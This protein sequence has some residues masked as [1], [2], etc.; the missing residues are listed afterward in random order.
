MFY[1]ISDLKKI[2]YLQKYIDNRKSNLKVAMRSI[3]YTVGWYNC[4]NEFIQII[5]P[6]N[7]DSRLE[8]SP[9]LYSFYDLRHILTNVGV[10]LSLEVNKVNGKV[11][12]SIPPYY[13][14]NMSKG[15]KSVLGLSSA[16]HLMSGTYIG[17]KPINFAPFGSLYI[18]L[19]QVKTENNIVDGAPSTV[20]AVV[21]VSDTPFGKSFTL[22]YDKPEF[23]E[24]INGTISELAVRVTDENNREID[25][26]GLPMSIV[27][28]FI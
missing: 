13:K 11:T 8:I 9:G 3:T 15:L 24:L 7:K 21:P 10:H 17:D 22:R 26:H 1:T 25:N 6:S 2:I 20:M 19:N 5:P 12:F 23:R 4:D 28:E 18:H 16:E 14:I 27:L